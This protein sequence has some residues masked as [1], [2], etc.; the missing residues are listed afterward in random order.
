MYHPVM[1]FYIHLHIFVSFHK[2]SSRPL[3]G[4]VPTPELQLLFQTFHRAADPPASYSLERRLAHTQDEKTHINTHK[5]KR[6]LSKTASVCML[7]ET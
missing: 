2:T 6:S 7:M 3:R 5:F 4:G 1:Q